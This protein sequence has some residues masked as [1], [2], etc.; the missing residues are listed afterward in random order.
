M[1]LSIVTLPPPP[2]H[3][4]SRDLPGD[5]VLYFVMSKVQP[6]VLPGTAGDIFL[7]NPQVGPRSITLGTFGQSPG[8]CGHPG[9][10]DFQPYI[11]PHKPEVG[12]GSAGTKYSVNPKV[13]SR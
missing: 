6:Q 5:S 1:Q 12:P 2:L 10:V 11:S 13:S 8:I 3:G 7:V 9:A 4:D